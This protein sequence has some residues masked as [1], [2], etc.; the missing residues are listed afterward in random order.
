MGDEEL[1]SEPAT[2]SVRH[3]EPNS[4]GSHT[5]RYYSDYNLPLH[6]RAWEWGKRF[7]SLLILLALVGTVVGVALK[8]A[9]RPSPTTGVVEIGG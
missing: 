6:L 2:S 8:S 4:E 3:A 5:F 1:P 9:E 7:T